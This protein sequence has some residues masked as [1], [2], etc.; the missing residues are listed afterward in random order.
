M[1]YDELTLQEKAKYLFTKF[2]IE[3]DK[4]DC[5]TEQSKVSCKYN[6]LQLTILKFLPN[7]ERVADLYNKLCRDYADR[8]HY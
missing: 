7:N 2:K 8:I 4:W 6:R 3:F 1:E 5:A